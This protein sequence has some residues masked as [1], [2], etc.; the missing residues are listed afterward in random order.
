MNS[1]REPNDEFDFKQLQLISPTVVPGGHHFIRFLTNESP[2]YIQP[3]KC[4]IKSG[5]VKA[6]KR[7]FCDLMFTNE[8]EHFIRW[9]ENL[10]TTSQKA[11]FNNR[12]KWFE[13]ELEE[14]DIE[15]SFT[16]P[17]K[18]YKSGKY[19]IVRVNIPL[20]LGKPN[21]KIYDDNENL[22]DIEN[23]HENDNVATILEIQGIKC[24]P[25]SFQIEIEMKQL[26][27][28]KPVDL[29]DKCVFKVNIS[30]PKSKTEPI[31]VPEPEPEPIAVPEQE[32]KKNGDMEEIEL[33]LE[34]LP[35]DTIFIKKRNDVYYEMYRDAL[36]K[37]KMAKDLALA[38]YLE[39]KRIKNTY[40][41]TDLNDEDSDFEDDIN[42]DE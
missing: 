27:I 24:S 4:K 18:I 2:L 41:L 26:L 1:I 15:N 25:R 21:L 8:N 36:R 32:P 14:H 30:E 6:G 37:A 12:A 31:A 42:I 13:T 16:S 10:E 19:Y 29:F 22:V 28:L 17:L 35:S 7:M 3:P 11:I 39:A 20:I 38:S 23:V 33:P 34:E 5:I 40:M 9:L